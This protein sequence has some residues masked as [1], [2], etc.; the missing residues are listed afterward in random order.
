MVNLEHKLTVDDLIIEYAMYK[1]KNDYEPSFSCSEFIDFLHYFE[2]DIEVE[3]SLYDSEELFQRFFERKRNFDWNNNSKEYNP[4]LEMI[5]DEELNENLIKA[6]YHLSAYDN[7]VINTYFMTRTEIEK[8]RKVIADYLEN[9]PK[10]QIDT[11]V[12]IN[13]D[14]LLIGKYVAT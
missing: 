8:I 11:S 4:H 13:S 14:N 9:H 3:D 7:S 6:N 1:V 2:S 12:E 5:Y 10:R